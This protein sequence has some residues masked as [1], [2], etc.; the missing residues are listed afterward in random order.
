[1]T[2]DPPPPEPGLDPYRVLEVHPDARPA[3][4][5]AAFTV[6]PVA[7]DDVYLHHFLKVHA[8]DIAR[9]HQQRN[10]TILVGFSHSSHQDRWEWVLLTSV[11]ALRWACSSR[12]SLGCRCNASKPLIS[13]EPISRIAKP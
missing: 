1:M 7:P 10:N 8:A 9:F 5:E 4:I 11:G 2:W 12:S 13:A 6:L 3:V